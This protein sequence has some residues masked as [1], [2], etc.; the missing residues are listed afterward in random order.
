MIHYRR[1]LHGLLRLYITLHP[2]DLSQQDRE[3]A[4]RNDDERIAGT[5]GI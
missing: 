5:A 3:N 2:V 1:S 4:F